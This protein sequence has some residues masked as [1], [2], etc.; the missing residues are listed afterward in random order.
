[1]RG[2]RIPG[3]RVIRAFLGLFTVLPRLALKPGPIGALRLDRLARGLEPRPMVPT[4]IIKKNLTI[5]DLDFVV[6]A[7]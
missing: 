7:E 4:I 2:A 5:L 1:M 6:D 3:R